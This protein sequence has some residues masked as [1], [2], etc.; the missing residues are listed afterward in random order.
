MVADVNGDGF[1]DII[2]FADD[3]VH[4]ALGNGD[5]TFRPLPSTLPQF[6]AN[7]GWNVD[8]HPRMLVDINKDG[9]A[10]ILGFANDGVHIALSNG[11]GTFRILPTVLPQ[12]GSAVGWNVD[13]PRMVADLNGDGFPDI[14]GFANDGVHVALGNGD[15]TFRPLPPTLP[16][17]GANAGWNV[18]RPRVLYDVN[19]DGFPDIVGFANDG[20]H[21]ALGNGDGT[22]RMLPQVL[23]AFGTDAG[24]NI[25]NH[26]RVFADVNG[27]GHLDIIG[28]ANDG[29]HIALGNGDGTF[30]PI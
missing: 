10:G 5:G 19:G 8:N 15:G 29:V 22:F 28:F 21:V 25:N 16:Q 4:V 30:Q 11:D 14:I 2:G 9:Q 17:F 3:G 27:D 20:V 7:A 1:P 26:P 12:F 24:W 18:L 6:G 13:R 23:P